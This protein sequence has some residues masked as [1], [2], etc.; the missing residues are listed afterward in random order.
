VVRL[1]TCWVN[2]R[3]AIGI[4]GVLADVAEEGYFVDVVWGGSVRGC[5]HIC[6]SSECMVSP[7]SGRHLSVNERFAYDS[8]I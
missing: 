7:R 3:T 8:M 2:C 5:R 4:A 1:L 6:A